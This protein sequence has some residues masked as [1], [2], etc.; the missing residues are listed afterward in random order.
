MSSPK[1]LFESWK[2]MEAHNER[3]PGPTRPIMLI[4][5]LKANLRFQQENFIK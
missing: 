5:Y 3:R 1:R 2:N 4:Y